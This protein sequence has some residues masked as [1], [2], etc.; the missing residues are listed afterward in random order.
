MI[1]FRSLVLILLSIAMTIIGCKKDDQF[2]P[3]YPN[4]DVITTK[5]TSA[6]KIFVLNEGNFT[7]GNATITSFS[8]TNSQVQQQVF[9]SE[10]Q[11]KLGDVAQ[12]LYQHGSIGYLAVNNSKTV[13]KVRLPQLT[14]LAKN[15]TLESPRY[16]HVM[17]NGRLWVTS[18]NKKSIYVL[19]TADLRVV[20]T[21]TVDGWHEELLEVNQQVFAC[22]VTRDWVS[23]FSLEGNLIKTIKTAKQPQSIALDKYGDVWVLCDGGWDRNNRENAQLTRIA[24]DQ[25]AITYRYVFDDIEASPT[26]LRYNLKNDRL[27]F[28]SHSCFSM[29]PGAI[30]DGPKLIYSGV[31]H[32]FYGL[33]CNPLTGD[34]ILTDAKSYSEPG[35]AIVVDQTGKFK[36]DFNTGYIPQ[37]VEVFN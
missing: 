13:F 32:N 16:T 21:I 8:L 7:Q 12:S 15:S 36:Y 30:S 19:D 31:G 10:N 3:Q 28:L 4:E 14:I 5:D 6:A 34:L 18:L 37:H 35:K 22:N 29:D 2:G 11:A 17:S 1:R 23:V 9:K 25:L 33:G 26:R 24:V 27:Y 20:N